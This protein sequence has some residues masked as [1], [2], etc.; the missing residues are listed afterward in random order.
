MV[1]HLREQPGRVSVQVRRIRWFT[2][3][4]GSTVLDQSCRDM[5]GRNYAELLEADALLPLSFSLSLSLSLFALSDV[6]F[7]KRVKL[8]STAALRE[9]VNHSKPEATKRL[10]RRL[11]VCRRK[12]SA[13][14]ADVVRLL[15]WVPVTAGV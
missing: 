5:C 3:S 1:S 6:S 9:A 14:V 7:H 8:D 13:I 12:R 10:W 4:Y 15:S 2:S 11:N